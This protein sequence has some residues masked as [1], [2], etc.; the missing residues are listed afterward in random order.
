MT[1]LF[2]KC[3]V[4]VL[5]GWLTLSVTGCVAVLAGGG[6]VLWQ[7]GKVISE[8]NTSLTKGVAAVETAFKNKKIAATDKVSKNAVT[9]LR[10]EDQAGTKV[11]V[12]IFSKGPKNVRIEIRYGIGE[13]S[14]ARD[15]LNE[16]KKRL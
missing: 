16:I 12:D 15:L 11:A 8:E 3:L 9:Q 13:E 5:A 14:P 4:L 1:N 10:G 2:K 6:A 7:A